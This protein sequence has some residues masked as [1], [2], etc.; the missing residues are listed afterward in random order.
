MIV[1]AKYKLPKDINLFSE[2]VINMKLDKK[3]DII[4]SHGGVW[5]FLEKVFLS[6]IFDDEKN[7]NAL[8]NIKYHLKNN[9]KFFINIQS[10]H[11]N[12]YTTLKKNIVFKQ[13]VEEKDNFC[14]KDYIFEKDEKILSTQRC[15]YK[16]KRDKEI[17]KLFKEC[18]F[19]DSGVTEDNKFRIYKLA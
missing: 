1:T 8:I 10:N 7:K 14:Y 4:F 19:I 5:V 16:L 2:D 12:S 9:G 6:H 17:D 13:I 15:T 3:F 18:G 11:S